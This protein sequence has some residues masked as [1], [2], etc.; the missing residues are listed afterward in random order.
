VKLCQFLAE[1][2]IDISPDLGYNFSVS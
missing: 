1:V 2:L